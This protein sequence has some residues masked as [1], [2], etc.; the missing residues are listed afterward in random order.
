MHHRP[1]SRTGR[2]SRATLVRFAWIVT[3]GSLL[4]VPVATASATTT[5]GAADLRVVVV[6]LLHGTFCDDGAQCAAP[7]RVTLFVRRLAEADC[8]EVVGIQEVSDVLRPLLAAASRTVCGGRYRTLF[9]TTTGNDEE[10]LL[11]TLRVRSTRLLDLP[12]PLRHAARAVLVDGPRDVVVVV[13]HQDGDA[14]FPVCRAEPA[15]YRCPAPCPEGTD[16]PTCQTILAERLT[17][18]GPRVDPAAVRVLMGDFNVVPGSP[19]YTR[20]VAGGWIDTHPAAGNPE[21]D[22]ATGK[23]CTSGRPDTSLAALRDPTAGQTERIDYIFVHPPK[24]C[25]PHF[26]GPDDADR[27]GLG[28]G[29]FAATPAV[30]GPGGLVWPSDHTAVS[31]D[32]SCR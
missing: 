17:R 18:P 20:L 14:N 28:T 3:L 6:N 21:C 30:D 13:T 5:D 26:D 27:D 31:M 24:G 9:A 32:M 7:D 2:R 25:T 16:F 12:G 19:R 10:L 8:P 23:G 11:T 22:P 29:P 1:S 15:R 4:A